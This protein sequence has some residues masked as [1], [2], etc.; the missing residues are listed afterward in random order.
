MTYDADT[1]GST[2]H[3]RQREDLEGD[4]PLL[5][6][7]ALRPRSYADAI[8]EALAGLRPDLMVRVVAPGGLEASV[9]GLDPDLVLCSQPLVSAV[10]G[11]RPLWVEY[12]P[13]A[14]GLGE[15]EV[16][17]DGHGLGLRGVDLLDLVEIL[18]CALARV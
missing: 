8:G 5:V 11:G 7:V 16:R 18:D 17:V 15:E 6:L 13:Y 14:D 10:R 2:T 3:G 12:C 9:R 1:T 4:R